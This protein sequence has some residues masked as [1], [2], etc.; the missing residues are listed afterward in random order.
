MSR[1]EKLLFPIIAIVAIAGMLLVGAGENVAVIIART[2]GIV[3]TALL[4]V[5]F[6][7]RSIVKYRRGKAQEQQM[8]AEF[9]AERERLLEEVAKEEAA[10]DGGA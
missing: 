9:Q 8:L 7:I 3:L 4:L 5:G 1:L 10:A 2:V 6:V